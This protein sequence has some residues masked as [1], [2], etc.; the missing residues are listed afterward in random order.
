MRAS[1]PLGTS[2]QG[3]APRCL[4]QAGES[5]AA[6][7]VQQ[8][9]TSSVRLSYPHSAF[10]ATEGRFPTALTITSITQE[11]GCLETE[12]GGGGCCASASL[13]NGVR[14]TSRVHTACFPPS[15]SERGTDGTHTLC[16]PAPHGRILLCFSGAGGQI[17]Q[18]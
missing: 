14:P 1:L 10:S 7:A 6:P 3:A 9:S 17:L 11:S 16:L 4:L 12:E 18:L 2:L 5:P 15:T 13:Q 8:H